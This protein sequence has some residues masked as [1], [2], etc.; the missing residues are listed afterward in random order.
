MNAV[1]VIIPTYNCAAFVP[2]AVAS[3]LAQ[4]LPAAEVIVV[5]DGSTDGTAEQLKPY[6]DRICVLRQENQGV[7]AARNHGIARAK[8]HFIAF[9]DSDDV[10]H[11][12]KLELQ[13]PILQRD[14]H[15]GLLGTAA[16]AHP[17]VSPPD[18]SPDATVI[19]VPWEKL[20]VKNYFTTSSILVRR[21]ILEKAGPFDTSL[22]GPEDY[23]LWLRIA[24]MTQVANLQ[25]L[26]TGYRSSHTG[27][28]NQARKMEAGLRRIQQKLAARAAWQQRAG[29]VLRQRAR[30]Y[31]GITC[32][33]MYAAAG[34]QSA[35]IGHILGSMGRYPLPLPRAETAA[36]LLRPRMLATA[37]LRSLRLKPELQT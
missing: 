5:D 36:A 4:T 12:R 28:G 27:L 11:P 31:L 21:E 18:V 25:A 22:Q 23:D 29:P 3:V 33:Q 19:N 26:L 37:V 20:V 32:A 34:L 14:T 13:V 30:A 16:F 17:H 2:Q 24:E 6:G 10:W 15:L 7:S 35:A 9:L 8:G 1:S